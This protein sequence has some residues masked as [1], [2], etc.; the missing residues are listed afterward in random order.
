MTDTLLCG[1]PYCS[2]WKEFFCFKQLDCKR[3]HFIIIISKRFTN[4][5]ADRASGCWTFNFLLKEKTQTKKTVR[6]DWMVSKLLFLFF[7]SNFLPTRASPA[8]CSQR[9][10]TFNNLLSETLFMNRIELVSPQKNHENKTT[11]SLLPT[12]E[13][14]N[15]AFIS[16]T[17]IC[18]HNNPE[19]LSGGL[20]WGVCEGGVGSGEV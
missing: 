16:K 20:G 5:G 3:L 7:C 9:Q 14:T 1:R 10:K 13:R 2:L 17:H 6:L 4:W 15:T 19:W 12:A 11:A 18:L 8:C